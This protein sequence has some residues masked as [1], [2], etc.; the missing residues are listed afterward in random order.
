VSR[1]SQPQWAAGAVPAAHTIQILAEPGIRSCSA[2]PSDRALKR[3]LRH[4]GLPNGCVRPAIHWIP[5]FGSVATQD[6]T[7]APSAHAS[8]L[9][10]RRELEDGRAAVGAPTSDHQRCVATPDSVTDDQLPALCELSDGCWEPFPPRL[11]SRSKSSKETT[12]SRVKH[13]RGEV[14]ATHD[15]THAAWAN[16]SRLPRGRSEL[17]ELNELHHESSRT[18]LPKMAS[19]G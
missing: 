5:G 13:R 10:V 15:A 9:R 18:V 2:T 1:E 16:A 7:P 12:T 11:N 14:H 17:S 19:Q 3:V 6:L 8:E 4:F